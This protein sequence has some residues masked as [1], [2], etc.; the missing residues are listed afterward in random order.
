[1]RVKVQIEKDI[2][3]FILFPPLFC[4]GVLAWF[5]RRTFPPPTSPTTSSNSNKSTIYFILF[6][7]SRRPPRYPKSAT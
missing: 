3:V 6:F 5:L 2:L 7:I 1:M 4:S